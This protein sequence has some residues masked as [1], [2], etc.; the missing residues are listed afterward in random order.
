MSV[1]KNICLFE[2]NDTKVKLVCIERVSSQLIYDANFCEESFDMNLFMKD[3]HVRIVINRKIYDV[4]MC[5][6]LNI[7][8]CWSVFMHAN[9]YE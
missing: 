2:V 9:E 5:N 4:S 3:L 8:G 1:Y 7:N 6:E